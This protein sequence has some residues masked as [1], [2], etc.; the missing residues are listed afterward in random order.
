MEH[1]D[2]IDEVIARWSEQFDKY[3]LGRRLQN[4]VIPASPAWASVLR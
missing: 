3:E 4:A 2:L 1:R